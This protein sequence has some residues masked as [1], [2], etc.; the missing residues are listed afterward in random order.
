K[1]L[2]KYGITVLAYQKR[3][4]GQSTGDCSMATIEDLAEDLHQAKKY[5][6]A[7]PNNYE[8]IGVLGISAGGWTMTKAE[9]QTDFDFMISI[10]GPS[11]SVKD[12]QLQSM[13][14]GAAFYKLSPNAKQNLRKYTNLMFDA[15]ETDAGFAEMERLLAKAKK[16]QWQQL[17]EDTDVPASSSDISNLWVRRHNYDPQKI[18]E[19]YNKP[20]LAIYG[21][22][23]WIVP[24]KEN[25]QLLEK[26]FAK[27]EAKLNTIVAY[28]AEHGMEMEARRVELSM[29]QSY[30]HFYRISP[31]V[32][33]EI[34]NFLMKYGLIE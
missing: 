34:V 20:F 2:R 31:E 17:L 5:L 8:K 12:Q 21:E 32:R 10:V 3:G 25:I 6:E 22:R 29:D 19:Q 9:E 18:L 1:F 30:W 15:E 24:P 28:N 27:K 16:E 13:E 33:I 23:D 11:T 26:Y 7:H 4:T 14:Y